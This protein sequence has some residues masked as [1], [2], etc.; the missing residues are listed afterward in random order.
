MRE[1]RTMA[2]WAIALFLAVM[3]VLAAADMLAPRPP[4][5]NHLFEVFRDASGIAY[6]EPTGRFAAGVL[7]VLVAVLMLLPAT[8]RIGAVL[9]FLLTVGIVALVAQLVVQQVPIPVDTIVKGADGADVVQ[10]TSTDGSQ[11]LYL[12]IGLA[13]ASLFLVFVHPGSDKAPAGTGPGYYGR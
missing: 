10:T 12:A 3:L 11:L 2:S 8:R 9:G 4:A 1:I 7:A 13:V 6:F 5:E